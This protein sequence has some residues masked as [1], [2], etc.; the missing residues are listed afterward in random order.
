MSLVTVAFCV[1]HRVCLRQP[2]AWHDHRR[3]YHIDRVETAAGN[4]SPTQEQ[5][6]Q[7]SH[8]APCESEPEPEPEPA[9]D[10]DADAD[11]MLVVCPDGV[12]PGEFIVVTAPDGREVEAEVRVALRRL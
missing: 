9:A 8:E 10:G 5:Q 1:E 6:A 3:R 11:F 2:D 12:G 7:P 4:A